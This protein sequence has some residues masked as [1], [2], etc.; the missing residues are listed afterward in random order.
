M[1]LFLREKSDGRSA[2]GYGLY[3]LGGLAVA[4]AVAFL[5]ARASG[6]RTGPSE[7]RRTRASDV[8][9]ITEPA[10]AVAPVKVDSRGRP[11]EYL[12][13]GPQDARPGELQATPG[14]DAGPPDSFD[15]ITA[16][17][18]PAPGQGEAGDDRGSSF[19]R[20]PPSYAMGEPAKGAPRPDESLLGYRDPS[21]DSVGETASG[22]GPVPAAAAAAFLV[23]KGTL[24]QAYL[25]TEGDTANPSA[26]LQFAAA[27]TLVFN[28]RS[29]LPFGTR[30]LGA[31]NGPPMRDRLNVAVD[32]IL[33]PNGLEL[34]I[35]GSCVE[36]GE[37]GFD[38]RP[39]VGAYYLPPPAWAQA[40]P[41]VS[42]L[43]TGYLGLLESRAQPQV[44]LGG[45]SFS[46]Q[47]SGAAAAEG[48]LYQASAQAIQAFTDAR[49]KELEQRYAAHYV[50]PAGTGCWLQLTADLDLGPAHPGPAKPDALPR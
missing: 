30:F 45:G 16:T 2:P 37:G 23:P 26:I 3:L 14:A 19:A 49:L 48:P 35:R 38:L 33:F 12:L 17:L 1:G 9:S 43:A 15:A 6:V 27:R 13:P 18:A 47:A 44:T 4:A 50:I 40:A 34:P 31:L 29:Q 21:A 22:F 42:D 28:H 5:H 8:A 46:I 36:A 25:L 7:H 11:A 39:G 10:A 20:L 41:Y 32:T 24:V